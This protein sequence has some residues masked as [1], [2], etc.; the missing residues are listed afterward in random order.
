[1][2]VSG[3]DSQGGSASVFLSRGSGFLCLLSLASVVPAPP[4][5]ACSTDQH[6]H[7]HR[8]TQTLFLNENLPAHVKL[9]KKD[10]IATFLLAEVSKSRIWR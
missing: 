7:A 2:S 5:G 10:S 8:D 9:S 3:A 6:N 4:H 1:M